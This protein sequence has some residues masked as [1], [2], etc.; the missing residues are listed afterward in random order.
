MKVLITGGA[1]F[2]GSQLGKHLHQMGHEVVL[3]DNMSF[4]H[5]DNL[6]LEGAPFGQFVCKDILD[7]DLA[8]HLQGVDTVFHLAGIAR[9]QS[10]SRIH[11]PHTT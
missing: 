2:V 1:G 10:V 8:A 5:L 3:L 7:A 11:A 6:L 9:S 4:G